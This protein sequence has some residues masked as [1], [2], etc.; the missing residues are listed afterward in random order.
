MTSAKSTEEFAID[1]RIST[2]KMIAQAGSSHIGSCLSMADIIAV[3]YDEVLNIDPRN[4]DWDQRDRFILSKG[5]A[6]AVVY[7]ALAERNFFPKSELMN[8]AQVGSSLMAH[9][10]HRVPG[11][12]FSTGSL[13]HGLPFGVGKA[14]G[15]KITGE[16][17]HTFVVL[18]D[19]ELD[20]GS[21]WEALLF[22]SHHKL[23][24]LTVIVDLNNLQSFTTTGETLN[25]APLPEKL[26]SFGADVVEIDGH[27][28]NE[29][30]Q[31]L[32]SSRTTEKPTVILAKT[33]KGKGVDYMEGLVEWHYKCPNPE[34][35]N[36]A[37]TQLEAQR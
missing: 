3:L 9:I 29:L 7:A 32:V 8:Y 34:Q 21:N 27:S 37:I 20:E 16:K 28:V 24:N 4:P 1:I 15:A 18:G 5:H 30:A 35:L 33:I 10:S 2:L 26:I 12:E 17:W 6:C 36:V 19:G 14:L 13:G 22:A 11:V 25:L 23:S 31:A